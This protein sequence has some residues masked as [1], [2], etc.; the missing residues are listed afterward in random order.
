M[1]VVGFRE[2]VVHYSGL[3]FTKPVKMVLSESRRD[4]HELTDM[5]V[6]LLAPA[7]APYLECLDPLG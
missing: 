5:G 2:W 3:G 1:T 6:V 4:P 7:L